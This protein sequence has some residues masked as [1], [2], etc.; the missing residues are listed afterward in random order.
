MKKLHLRP[1]LLEF[2]RTHLILTAAGALFTVLVLMVST[3]FGL[4]ELLLETLPKE[5]TDISR[6]TVGA[7]PALLP[8]LLTLACYLPAGRLARR[9]G[10]V[11]PP[12]A[13]DALL[14]LIIPA[15]AFW[16]LLGLAY[17][18][19]HGGGLVVAAALLNC[20]A[21]GMFLLWTVFT[22]WGAMAPEWAGYMAGLVSGLLPP[23]LF[24]VGC[25]LPFRT[26]DRETGKGPA[27]E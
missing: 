9:R 11:E 17:L 4:G 19:P 6:A 3:I 22:G 1:I 15:A 13:D 12:R 10:D 18:V 26:Y 27:E 25:G 24:L 21:Y 7:L 20:P 8:P 14:L 16:F 23:L 2:L 5:W